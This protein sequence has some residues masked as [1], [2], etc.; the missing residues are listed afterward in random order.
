MLRIKPPAVPSLTE[1]EKRMPVALEINVAL[2]GMI[3]CSGI[4]LIGW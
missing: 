1:L 4:K 2:W 3:I